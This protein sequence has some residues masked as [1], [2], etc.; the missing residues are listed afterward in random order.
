[1]INKKLLIL[2]FT[3]SI[4]Q[5]FAGTPYNLA[6]QEACIKKGSSVPGLMR[7]GFRSPKAEIS[8]GSAVLISA[9]SIGLPV[10]YEGRLFVSAR[11][12]FASYLKT[13]KDDIKMNG[14]E[15]YSPADIKRIANHFAGENF[16]L[17][18]ETPGSDKPARH[19]IKKL[20]CPIQPK[21]IQDSNEVD[22]ND[23]I[24][25]LLSER[26]VGVQMPK[27][28]S[29]A[30]EEIT[31]L[32]LVSAGFGGNQIAFTTIYDDLARAGDQTTTTRRGKSCFVGVPTLSEDKEET[33]PI[34]SENGDSGGAGF[35]LSEDGEMHL[36]GII[37]GGLQATPVH[38]NSVVNIDRKSRMMHESIAHY[39]DDLEKK[40]GRFISK[41]LEKS[42]IQGFKE[43][44]LGAIQSALHE[45]R[46]WISSTIQ[47]F[48]NKKRNKG[49][50]YLHIKDK[51]EDFVD[52]FKSN[53]KI[54]KSNPEF[55][56]LKY[57]KKSDRIVIV[58][59]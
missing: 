5:V 32:P 7:V 31:S 52:H 40:Y 3:L 38:F 23:I 57:S 42:L 55:T 26:V 12:V 33:T 46:S 37:I 36:A 18:S 28:S 22:D 58:I 39:Y 51:I 27:I 34:Y 45:V 35:V 8:L 20:F 6:D 9:E 11:H 54:I 15:E 24:F 19:S 16:F 59:D 49:T 17:S 44:P 53:E 21:K 10:A 13:I 2:G 43:N 30:Y 4:G 1:M 56:I 41:G 50:I 47:E 29:T 48:F 25:G 14:S